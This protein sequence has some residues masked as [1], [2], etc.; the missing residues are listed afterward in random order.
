L[1]A[2]TVPLIAC[3]NCDLLQ[4]M[5]PLAANTRAECARCGAVLYGEKGA[6]I[7][8]TFALYLAAGVL[9]LL[10]N[11]YPFL[12]LSMQGLVQSGYLA[13]SAVA[14]WRQGMPEVAIVIAFFVI[15]APMVRIAAGLAVLGPL[16]FGYRPPWLAP[17]M[18]MMHAMKEWAMPE[19]FVLGVLVSYVKLAGL[20]SAHFDVSFYA[21]VAM[22]VMLSWAQVAFEPHV[23]WDTLR[24]MSRYPPPDAAERRRLVS[25]HACGLIC[26]IGA[27][28]HGHCP[29]C[30]AAVHR[31]KRDSLNRALAL[32]I[33]AAIF[34]VPANALPVMTIVFLGTGSP[35]TILGGVVELIDYG[36]WPLAALIFFASVTV[37]LAKL[38]SLLYLILSVKS[39]SRFRP[40]QRTFL[41]RLVEGVGRWS[42]ID[43]FV[44]GLLTSLVQF[45]SLSVIEPGAGAVYFCGVV[46]VTIFAAIAFDPRLIWDAAG[47]NDDRLP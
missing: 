2:G 29:R 13:A 44:V 41:F 10:A 45:G 21:F 6:T 14:L 31:R 43:V 28:E 26:D 36:D 19:V 9:F 35:A 5:E 25:C 24:P 1:S 40:R 27:A 20:A 4:V 11:A 37:P 38:V 30:G 42:M 7:E 39:R 46:V 33:A 22:T 3:F 47:E 32:V 15:I 12:T 34:Y 23:V 18:H 17:A 8:R 16:T